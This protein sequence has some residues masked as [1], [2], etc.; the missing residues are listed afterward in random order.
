[1]RGSPKIAIAAQILHRGGVIA[2]PTEAVWGLGADPLDRDA[3]AYLLE[4]KRRSVDR[5]LILVAASIEQ[6]DFLLAG[7]RNSDIAK[8]HMSW[9]GAN[10]WLI[11]HR[12]LIPPWICGRH[13]SVAVRVS[14]H[15]V[16]KSLCERFGGPIVSTSANPRGLAPA[17][18]ALRA[19]AYFGSA[20]YYVP[21]QV[22]MHARPSVIRDLLTEQVLR[23]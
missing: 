1:M 4:L 6:F 13:D 22:D 11:P 16:V 20:V 17:R 15:P 2:Y 19:R 3:V 12:D 18:N 8:L 9:P 21:G 5:G 10:T 23:A 14:A 7:L